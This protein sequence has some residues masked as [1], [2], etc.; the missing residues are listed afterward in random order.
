VGLRTVD[1]GNLVR[2]GDVAGIVTITQMQPISVLFTI[3]EPDL[4]AVRAAT[5]AQPGLPVEAWGRDE[6]NRLATGQLLSMDN[7][8]DTA[9]GTVRMRAQFENQDESLFPNQFVNIRLRVRNE[10]AIVIPNAA[11]QFGSQGNFVYVIDNGLK[12]T[13][14]AVEL[15]ATEGERVAV[16]KGVRAGEKVV[17]EGLD[18][19]R[20]GREVEI[21]STPVADPPVAAK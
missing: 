3:A 11:V 9:T 20:E 19:L 14:R 10:A 6:R 15:G 21:V 12:A 7:L 8:I 4:P 5:R 17:L 13:L 18:R 1:A 2:A 16:I